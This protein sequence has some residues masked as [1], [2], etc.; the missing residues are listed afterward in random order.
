MSETSI[1]AVRLVVEP[2]EPVG[3]RKPMASPLIDGRFGNVS[4]RLGQELCHMVAGGHLV[5]VEGMVQGGRCRWRGCIVNGATQNM[6]Q[7]AEYVM[8]AIANKDD[9]TTK[10]A[11]GSDRL[12]WTVKVEKVGLDAESQALDAEPDADAAG[13]AQGQLRE[14]F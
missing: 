8:N 14:A 6:R 3:D 12:P 7:G 5:W 11:Y 9:G 13:E 10:V 2:L 4:E 1:N